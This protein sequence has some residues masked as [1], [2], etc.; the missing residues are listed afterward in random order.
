MSDKSEKSHQWS[1][2][3]DLDAPQ[4]TD[5]ANVS[6]KIEKPYNE[7][8]E[9]F[10]TPQKSNFGVSSFAQSVDESATINKSN[11]FQIVAAEEN[12]FVAAKEVPIRKYETTIRKYPKSEKG[13]TVYGTSIFRKIKNKKIF[14]VGEGDFTGAQIV[15]F[16]D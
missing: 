2:L 8:S 1:W 5:L 15:C 16:G 12:A 7:N 13:C 14:K 9:L 10:K 6:T 3:D 11:L 4:W